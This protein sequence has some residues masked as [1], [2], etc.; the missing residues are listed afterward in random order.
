MRTRHHEDI[1]Q[2]FLKPIL[3]SW[4]LP[5]FLSSFLTSLGILAPV[6]SSIP[7]ATCQAAVSRWTPR[8]H[9]PL[10]HPRQALL[11]TMGYAMLRIRCVHHKYASLVSIRARVWQWMCPMHAGIHKQLA[12]VALT[13]GRI[14][15]NIH[16]SNCMYHRRD[17]LHD[18]R[19]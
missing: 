6:R 7:C 13:F 11:W 19:R 5:P 9:L 18:I 4:S 15:C 8:N 17:C 12:D 2:R 1:F 10:Y 16:A 3:I 14:Q